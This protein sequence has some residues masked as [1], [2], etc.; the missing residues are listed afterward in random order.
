MKHKNI[1]TLMVQSGFIALFLIIVK[2]SKGSL[3]ILIERDEKGQLVSID[4]CS[5]FLMKKKSLFVK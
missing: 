1:L 5:K 3:T 2:C 4:I